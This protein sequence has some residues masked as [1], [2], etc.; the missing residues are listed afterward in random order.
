MKTPVLLISD[1]SAVLKLV[2][3]VSKLVPVKDLTK[4]TP[5]EVESFF[6][7]NFLAKKG[8]LFYLCILNVTQ[9]RGIDPPTNAAIEN[10]GGLLTIIAV[11]PRNIRELEQFKGRTK[12]MSNK[13]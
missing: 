2:S 9:G 1:L 12:R 8:E 6:K 11:L 13:G 5:V 7:S 3:S 4:S 10:E